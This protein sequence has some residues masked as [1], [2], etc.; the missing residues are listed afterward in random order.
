ME[1]P[2][3]GCTSEKEREEPEMKKLFSLLLVLFLA[4]AMM[5]AMAEVAADTL[6]G[7]WYL[8]SIYNGE[9]TLDPAMLGMKMVLT[10]KEDGTAVLAAQTG[11][12]EMNKEGTW[13]FADGAVSLTVDG[14]TIAMPV[15]EDGTLKG[16]MNGSGMV[17]GREAPEAAKIPQPVP[18][19]SEEAFLGTWKAT[20]INMDGVTL[21]LDT[22][23]SSG[24]DISAALTIEAGKASLKVNFM[25]ELPEIAGTTTFE[26]GQLLLGVEGAETPL[27]IQMTDTGAIYLDFTLETSQTNIP[28]YFEKAE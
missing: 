20:M 11:E 6:L 26:N 15:Q 3:C 22:L 9:A 5:P 4:C 23:A 1:K 28:L 21:P 25:I 17:F 10:L 18:A 19:E 27:A 12:Q 2:R 8:V 13:A 7:E 16:E 24:M 14:E